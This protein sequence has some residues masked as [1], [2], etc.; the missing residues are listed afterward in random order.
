MAR[1]IGRRPDH[2]RSRGVYTHDWWELEFGFGSSPLAR[3]LPART[4]TIRD[5][6]RI[7]PARAGFTTTAPYGRAEPKDHPRSRGV[8]ADRFL[9]AVRATGSSPL[10]RGLHDW[11]EIEFGCFGIIPARAG[12]TTGSETSSPPQ[13]DHPRSRGVYRSSRRRSPSTAGS[14]PLARGLPGPGP[15]SWPPARIIPARAG[16][17]RRRA[18][19]PVPRPDHPRSRGVYTSASRSFWGWAG[20]SPLARGL[21]SQGP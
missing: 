9:E 6:W 1:P 4:A 14:S 20:S 2:P 8:Y 19:V 10:A 12:F 5:L 15:P 21:P 17:T 7:I 13:P 3:G 18:G 16:F 11:W